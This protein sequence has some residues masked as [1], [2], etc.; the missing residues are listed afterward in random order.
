[1]SEIRDKK[2]HEELDEIFANTLYGGIYSGMS[3]GA[4]GDSGIEKGRIEIL[5]ASNQKGGKAI[6]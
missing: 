4:H 2:K 5:T 3:G 1:M 6:I